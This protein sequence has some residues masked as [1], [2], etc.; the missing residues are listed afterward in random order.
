[1]DGPDDKPPETFSFD[2]HGGTASPPFNPTQ[3]LQQMGFQMPNGTKSHNRGPCRCGYKHYCDGEEYDYVFS[4]SGVPLGFNTGDNCQTVATKFV[5]KHKP[6]FGNTPLI[7]EIAKHIRQALHEHHGGNIPEGAIGGNQP[8]RKYVEEKAEIY[9]PT[10]NTTQLKDGKFVKTVYPGGEWDK[11][12]SEDVIL[13]KAAAKKVLEAEK[14]E[15]E[16]I[17]QQLLLHE[18]ERRKENERLREI[19]RT[20]NLAQPKKKEGGD[21][22]QVVV[23]GVVQMVTKDERA[24][25][26]GEQ[27]ITERVIGLND[28]DDEEEETSTGKTFAVS[29]PPANI[30]MDELQ[31]GHI[32]AKLQ[33][34]GLQGTQ[35]W[36]EGLGIEPE[37]RS[38]LIMKVMAAAASGMFGDGRISSDKN[39]K[40]KD[41]PWGGAA[42]SLSGSS[43]TGPTAPPSLETSDISQPTSEIETG[44]PYEANYKIVVDKSQ[45]K[46]TLRITLKNKTL[47]DVELNTEIHTLTNLHN[48]IRNVT[49][50]KYFHIF[51]I[52]QGKPIKLENWSGTMKEIGLV[53]NARLNL[54]EI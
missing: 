18:Q 36:L 46:V 32:F 37:M 28:L 33:S 40:K 50:L 30:K 15:K 12:E 6:G 23:G 24:Q 41:D 29:L 25:M 19:Q 13:H 53:R 4:I 20:R 31:P 27:T 43:S 54:E 48:H 35:T 44:P 39:Q 2:D 3:S 5:A 52:A 11:I 1:M 16:K 45:P 26:K 34:E 14:E 47:C 51:D 42:I 7:A 49:Q 9:R 17:K 22:V 38:L 8:E 10:K 21:L